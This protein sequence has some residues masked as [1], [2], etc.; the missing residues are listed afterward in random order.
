MNSFYIT[1]LSDSSMNMF[2]NNTQSAFRTKLIKPIS[3]QKEDWEVALV[4]IIHPVEMYN[5]SE[6]ESRFQIVSTRP[7]VINILKDI[8]VPCEITRKND[9]SIPICIQPG[10]YISAK[11]LVSEIDAAIE[12]TVG[13]ALKKV[14]I[15]LNLE[16]SNTA[17]R[18]KFSKISKDGAGIRFHPNLLLKLG[19][20]P[21][22]MFGEVYVNDKQPFT[23]DVDLYAGFNHLFVYSDIADFTMLGDIEAPILRVIPNEQSEAIHVH[24]EFLNLHYVPIAKS[25]F[26]D[27]NINIRGSTGELVH[28][29]GGKSMVKLHFKRKSTLNL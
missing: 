11:H 20:R 18:V 12:K 8:K 9:N 28:F 16:Y 17:K 25:Y 1:L 3:I 13:E 4:E 14:H 2:P 22:K 27:I 24:K 19:G 10:S 15:Y 29:A 5:I 21:E 26:D 23:Y 6:A 7:E